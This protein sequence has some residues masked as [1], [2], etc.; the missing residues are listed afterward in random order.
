MACFLQAENLLL[1]ANGNIKI[2]GKLSVVCQRESQPITSHLATVGLIHDLA[3]KERL[4]IILH[5]YN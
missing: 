2:A 4:F 1:D 3:V 5:M